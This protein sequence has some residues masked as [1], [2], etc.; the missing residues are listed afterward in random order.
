MT[1]PDTDT[2]SYSVVWTNCARDNART[3]GTQSR[4]PTR[5]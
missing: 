3:A 2:Q 4:S 1:I 5:R